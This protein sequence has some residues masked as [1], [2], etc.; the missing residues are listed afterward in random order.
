[1]AD[2]LQQIP[3]VALHSSAFWFVVHFV[4]NQSGCEGAD[5][6]READLRRHPGHEKTTGNRKS[7]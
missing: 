2:R 4:E 6:W 1:M 5:D 7:Q 3:K